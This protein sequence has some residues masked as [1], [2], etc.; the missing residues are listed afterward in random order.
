M[1][2]TNRNQRIS[3]PIAVNPKDKSAADVSRRSAGAS[4]GSFLFASTFS[5]TA[6]FGNASFGTASFGTAAS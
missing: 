6:G 1:L 3:S 4:T 2:D 5:S